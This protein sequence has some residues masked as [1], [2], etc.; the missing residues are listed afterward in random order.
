MLKFRR[1][2]SLA[3]SLLIALP[4]VTSGCAK[5]EQ[6]SV[7]RVRLRVFSVKTD[8]VDQDPYQGVGLMRVA[9]NRASQLIS[10]EFFTFDK[11]LGRSLDDIPFGA[12][13]QVT[14]E[15]WSA[16]TDPKSGALTPSQL[17]SRGRSARFTMAEGGDAIT[18]QIPMSRL[19]TF[20]YT[21][22][23][24]TS[25]G[26]TAT[27]LAR[28]RFGHTV[29]R[30]YDGRVLI[31]GGLAFK[32]GHQGDFTNANQLSELYRDAELYDPR[33][34]AFLPTGNLASAR[35]FH[36]ATY[37][38]PTVTCPNPSGSPATCMAPQGLVVISGGLSS[39]GGAAQSANSIEVYD[40]VAGT[41]QTVA[42][43]T[44]GEGRSGH[45]STLLDSNGFVLLAGG[46]SVKGDGAL[47][48]SGTG[49]VFC[50]DGLACSASST[51]AGIIF[52]DNM[53]QSRAFH[54]ADRVDLGPRGIAGQELVEAVVLI[55]GESDDEVRATTEVFLLKGGFKKVDVASLPTM[56]PE[57]ARRPR[58]RHTA[59]YVDPQKFIHV[60]GGFANK[61]HSKTVQ[62]IDSF[63][64][65]TQAFQAGTAF[66]S[67]EGRG[68]HAAVLMDRNAVLLLGGFAQGA[69]IDAEAGVYGP[70]VPLASAELIFERKDPNDGKT[71]IDRGSVGSLLKPR[72]GA[73]GLF[74]EN[75][76]AIVI[77]G[78]DA[79]SR[80]QTAGEFFNPL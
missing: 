35:A 52:T 14:I 58:T 70:G 11:S 55:G 7:D 25:T 32:E 44:L 68:A 69:V 51:G 48:A 9:V 72:G 80:F 24:G 73:M 46:F 12:N 53:V 61:A 76:T 1:A 6:G 10:D 45:T 49:E 41:F 56:G 26:A 62:Q 63:D 16:V 71:Y 39:T 5:E 37:L 13:L 30:L 29:T 47:A 40:P 31:T 21:S 15:G 67:V 36:A 50:L 78:V 54:T 65:Q 66:F 20:A 4:I 27:S 74:L 34:G 43:A 75:N 60:V 77:G 19:S 33:S 79:T 18:L 59:T 8:S 23:V 28:G 42:S 3:A 64:V 38:P 17:L 57:S 22:Q 2:F